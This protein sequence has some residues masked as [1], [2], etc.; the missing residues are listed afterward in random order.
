MALILSMALIIAIAL[1]VSAAE[2]YAEKVFMVRCPNGAVDLEIDV[3]IGDKTYSI[4]TT[5]DEGVA[6]E[7]PVIVANLMAE[8]EADPPTTVNVAIH[9]GDA[10][11]SD[12]T[13][14]AKTPGQAGNDLIIFKIVQSDGTSVA[15]FIT[16]EENLELTVLVD[17]TETPPDGADETPGEAVETPTEEEAVDEEE[18]PA[19]D[20][21]LEEP[22]VDDEVEEPT[23]D[24]V[25]APPAETTAPPV[26]APPVNPRTGVGSTILIAIGAFVTTT[27]G[28]VLL[29]RKIK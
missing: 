28:M 6:T 24:E 8:V 10:T 19:V 4:V 23:V 18:E 16:Y 20:E 14:T 21:E 3:T 2:L 26:T 29:R 15:E 12:I 7:A 25:P 9:P 11:G 17:I 22:T 27:G 1:P 5:N 13:V